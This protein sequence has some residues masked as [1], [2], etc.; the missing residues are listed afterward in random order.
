MSKVALEFYSG[1]GMYGSTT[2]EGFPP[3]PR[4]QVGYT[5]RSNVDASI[6]QAFDWDQT[7]CQV[8]EANHGPNIIN[9]VMPNTVLIHTN[10][11]T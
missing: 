11:Y 5:L 3:I 4:L 7:A 9:K 2:C 10:P 6:V 1:I 8:Y